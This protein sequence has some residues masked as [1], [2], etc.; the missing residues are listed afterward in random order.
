MIAAKVEGDLVSIKELF[1]LS[2]DKKEK[3]QTEKQVIKEENI[4]DWF[5][6]WLNVVKE[7]LL[8]NFNNDKCKTYINA[9]N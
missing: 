6:R 4:D 9:L 3:I 1:S 2:T 8:S 5:E 7:M